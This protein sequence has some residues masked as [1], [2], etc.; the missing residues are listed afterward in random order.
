[1]IP[2]LVLLAFCLEEEEP[3]LIKMIQEKDRRLHK[4]YL[5]DLKVEWLASGTGFEITEYDG[6]ESINTDDFPWKA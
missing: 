6:S 2:A 1:M 3:M 5:Y 4:S